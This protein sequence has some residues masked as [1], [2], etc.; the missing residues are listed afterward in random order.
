MFHLLQR[1]EKPVGLEEE[2]QEVLVETFK[3]HSKSVFRPAEDSWIQH[4]DAEII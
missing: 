4:I 1:P 3:Y 2:V